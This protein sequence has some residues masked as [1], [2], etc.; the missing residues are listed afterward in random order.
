MYDERSGPKNIDHIVSYL[1]QYLQE[2]RKI[3]S[4]MKRLHIFM[5]NACSTNKKHLTLGWVSELIQQNDF[6][7]IRISFSIAGHTKF[8]PDLLFSKIARAFLRSDGFTTTDLGD[9][10]RQYGDVVIDEGEK[11]LQWRS[12]LAKYSTLPGIH[13]LHDF[14]FVHPGSVKL[15][16]I[17]DKYKT[18]HFML[19]EAT[20]WPQLYL[21]KAG[22]SPMLAFDP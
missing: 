1:T 22:A 17:R 15:F 18:R 2:S 21:T 3:P 7:Y 8:G 11:V 10:A 9:V 16:V 6:D 13:T 5:D 19:S 14:V 12:S 4:W 20:N